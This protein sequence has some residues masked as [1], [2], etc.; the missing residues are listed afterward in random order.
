MIGSNVITEQFI[1]ANLKIFNYGDLAFTEVQSR[2]PT[3]DNDDNSQCIATAQ[4]R[5]VWTGQNTLTFNRADVASRLTDHPSISSSSDPVTLTRDLA[6]RLGLYFDDGDLAD[7]D[8]SPVTEPTEITFAPKADAFAT[9]GSVTVTKYPPAIIQRT[10][11]VIP[12]DEDG[13]DT[14]P[15]SMESG[16]YYEFPFSRVPTL[17]PLESI[18]YE[19]YAGERPGGSPAYANHGLHAFQRDGAWWIRIYAPLIFNAGILTST[20]SQLLNFNFLDSAQQASFSVKMAPPTENTIEVDG[21]KLVMCGGQYDNRIVL[22]RGESVIVPIEYI[23]QVEMPEKKLSTISCTVD[24]IVGAICVTHM[25]GGIA[26]GLP[27][28]IYVKV[29]NNIEGDAQD[30]TISFANVTTDGQSYAATLYFTFE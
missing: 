21:A 29:T 17:A 23:A 2:S 6:Y 19:L 16:K 14:H 12:D 10:A 26:L 25:T 15:F 28:D 3:D 8:L 20:A 1:N 13:T 18:A 7:V 24:G 4:S 5:S 9:Y 11:G 22:P 27:S 30:G